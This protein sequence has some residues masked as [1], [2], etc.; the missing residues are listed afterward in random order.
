[1]SVKLALHCSSPLQDPVVHGPNPPPKSAP[2][3]SKLVPKQECSKKHQKVFVIAQGLT[4]RA[5]SFFPV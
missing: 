5:G 1:M 2:G 3:L 4:I